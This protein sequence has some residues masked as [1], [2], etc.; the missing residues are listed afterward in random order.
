M[1]STRSLPE[2]P[3]RGVRPAAMS[4]AVSLFIGADS[5]MR[6]GLSEATQERDDAPQRRPG[7]TGRKIADCRPFSN[8][9]QSGIGQ[10]QLAD[11]ADVEALLNGERPHG[12]ELAGMR[13]HDSGAENDPFVRSD[14]LDVSARVT[15][16]L[17][18][19]VVVKG[20]A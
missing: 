5:V 17:S 11:G 2:S 14:H 7:Q 10:D 9:R 12:D 18:P 3:K 6:R 4:V 16:R 13:P 20:S 15:L 8:F 19:V 1:V